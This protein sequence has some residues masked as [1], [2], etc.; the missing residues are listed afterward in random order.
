MTCFPYYILMHTDYGRPERKQPKLHSRKFNPNPKL[1]GMAAAYFVCH[2]G[3]IFQISL[4]YA[5]I[6]CPQSVSTT[7]VW[8]GPMTSGNFA[9]MDRSV[10]QIGEE[11]GPSPTPLSC[12]LQTN[13][14][15]QKYLLFLT[16]SNTHGHSTRMWHLRVD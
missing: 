9:N 16:S 7:I 4:I 11:W 14:L 15:S 1:L 5:F 12:T 6:G 8:R 10:R 2:T 13:N 3:H